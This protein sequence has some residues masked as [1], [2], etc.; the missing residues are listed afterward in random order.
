MLLVIIADKELDL[1]IMFYSSLPMLSVF[2]SN[3]LKHD[4]YSDK[5]QAQLWMS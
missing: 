2:I 1:L 5:S 3:P 4:L